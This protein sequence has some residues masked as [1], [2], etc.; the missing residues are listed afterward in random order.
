M[1]RRIA[2]GRSANTRRRLRLRTRSRNTRW[3]LSIRHLQ[4]SLRSP[5]FGLISALLHRLRYRRSAGTMNGKDGRGE[6]A[7]RASPATDRQQPSCPPGCS[8][9]GQLL[10]YARPASRRLHD[11]IAR[12][13]A[14]DEP[15]TFEEL[16]ADQS[17]GDGADAA[18]DYR[19]AAALLAV[20]CEL[21]MERAGQALAAARAGRVAIAVERYRRRQGKLPASLTDLASPLD[22]KSTRLN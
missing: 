1:R 5:P 2:R 13:R 16:R 18:S 20:A 14:A 3:M 11:E 22:R 8:R 15:L 7:Q 6:A 19:A 17:A 10:G 9:A 12:I 4:A 21:P